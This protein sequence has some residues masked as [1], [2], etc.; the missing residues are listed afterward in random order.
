MLDFHVHVQMTLSY[1][2]F[3]KHIVH[4]P[5]IGLSNIWG[6]RWCNYAYFLARGK[7]GG[8]NKSGL[9]TKF[10]R[11]IIKIDIK[12]IGI[13]HEKQKIALILLKTMKNDIFGC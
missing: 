3:Q 9:G 11:N 10:G 4:V 12:N 1:P 2:P 7:T 8:L 6:L 13:N 5:E